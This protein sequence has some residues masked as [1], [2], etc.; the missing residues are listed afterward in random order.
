[1]TKKLFV[2]C[3]LLILAV[4][5]YATDTS[6]R[7]LLPENTLFTITVS[8]A[9][10]FV[11]S[12]ESSPFGK[13]WKT[14]EMSEFLNGHTFDSLLKDALFDDTIKDKN[15]AEKKYQLELEEFKMLKGEI[16][17]AFMSDNPDDESMYIIAEMNQEDYEK[18]LKLDRQI[19]DLEETKTTLK[20]EI[21]QG[22]NIYSYIEELDQNE[23]QIHFQ[24]HHNN[25]LLASDNL[26]WV[27]SSLI[28]LKKNDSFKT[29]KHTA[30][31]IH[32]SPAIL[33]KLTTE[34]NAGAE[35]PLFDFDVILK[36]LGISYFN[37]LT[38]NLT[39]SEKMSE[40]K[41]DIN[42]TSG[43]KGLWS[44][45]TTKPIPPDFRLPYVP[46]DIHAYELSQV[47]LHALWK[48]IPEIITQ[49]NPDYAA[50]F[51]ATLEQIGAMV[52][53]NINDDIFAN[54]DTLHFNYA[55]FDNLRQQFVYGIKLN[56][57][58]HMQRVLNTL[59]ADNSFIRMQL[60][61]RYIPVT[62]GDK[63]IHVIQIPEQTADTN[64][65]IQYL[66]IALAVS[67]G[68]LIV[69]SEQLVTDFVEAEKPGQT[70]V[71]FY[72][73]RLYAKS[74]SAIP[75]NINGYS[76]GKLS[77][78]IEFIAEKLK[79]TGFIN[80]LGEQEETL[81][82]SGKQS[83]QP[84]GL[85]SKFNFEKFPEAEVISTYF[86]DSVSYYINNKSAVQYRT[87][88]YYPEN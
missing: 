30:C 33:N 48:Q 34:I 76:L 87:L 44:L 40:I 59:F 27:K 43:G 20:T 41:T 75:D 56:D 82:Q 2:L 38:I 45:F 47:D 42:H 51:N 32:V 7:S 52:N 24:S 57:Q 86:G 28:K 60:N 46:D 14:K 13:L 50:Q 81:E 11:Q 3:C 78:T 80:M 62:L 72:K 71:P 37:G 73:S 49:I 8:D 68:S 55:K 53:I 79:Q 67:H 19:F 17:V 4:S 16:A 31:T 63:N 65:E 26:E 88:L 58:S 9:E 15:A 39:M 10:N 5:G 29:N 66:H 1:M 6:R 36:A 18:S 69:G 70:P 77:E 22:I 64:Q 21:F 25:T 23:P 74:E 54:L 84:V 12:V 85:L 83:E 35:K 61:E